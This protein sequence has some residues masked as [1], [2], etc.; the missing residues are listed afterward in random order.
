MCSAQEPVALDSNTF[1]G[2][3]TNTT[4]DV[5]RVDTALSV[6]IFSR[7]KSQFQKETS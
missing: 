1:L 3:E 2:N 6:D 4:I 5:T 7:F